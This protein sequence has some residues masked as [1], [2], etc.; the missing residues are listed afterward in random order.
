MS[1][2]ETHCPPR[3][4]RSRGSRVTTVSG[5]TSPAARDSRL[6]E[7]RA[8]RSG[9]QESWWSPLPSNPPRSAP[10]GQSSRSIH[11]RGYGMPRTNALG[12]WVNRGKRQDRSTDF[13][14]GRTPSRLTCRTRLSSEGVLEDRAQTRLLAVL[15]DGFLHLQY[16]FPAAK[17]EG[18]DVVIEP[19][20]SARQ[21]PADS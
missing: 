2:E 1:S 16:G 9:Y 7:S 21:P 5:K 8:Y 17:R 6:L 12:R 3:K 19:R 20:F 13:L 15:P 18:R 10:R 14:Y 4:R 11:Y